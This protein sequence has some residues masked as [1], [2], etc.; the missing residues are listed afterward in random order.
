METGYRVATQAG[1]RLR[2]IGEIVTQSAALAQA[3]SQATNAQ[4]AGVEQVGSKVQSMAQIASRARETG[5]EGRQTAEKLQQ[6]AEQ[7]TA[8]LERFR[9]A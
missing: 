2:E 8:N 7:L 4:V 6:L 1:E 5:Q 3:I 9:L